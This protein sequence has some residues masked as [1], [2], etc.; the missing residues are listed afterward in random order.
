MT[1]TAPLTLPAE[2]TPAVL[3]DLN[4]QI[5]AALRLNKYMGGQVPTVPQMAFMVAQNKEV[6]YGGA[7]K[8]GKTSGQLMAAMQFVDFPYYNAL[9]LHRTF[10]DLNRGDGIIP[11]FRDWTDSLGVK[12]DDENHAG[13]FP[14]GAK[15]TF[16][17]IEHPGD[18][19]R[20]KMANYQYIGWEEL[21]EQPD[22]APY[23]YLF[24]RLSRPAGSPIPLRVRANSN[25]D[26][27]GRVW[28]KARFGIGEDAPPCPPSR[29]FIPAKLDDNPHVDQE[30]IESGLVELD[31]V[32]YAQLRNGNWDV[33]S[34]GDLFQPGKIRRLDALPTAGVV[35]R[36][37][38][39]DKA[40]TGAD[41][42][43]KLGKKR[44]AN[45][46]FTVGVRMSK[47]SKALY[48]VEYVVEDVIRGQWSS[49]PRDRVI[50][51]ATGIYRPDELTPAGVALRIVR[52]P[53]PVPTEIYVEQEPASGGKQSAEITV[54]DL[55]G[56]IVHIVLP[57]GDKITRARPFASMIENGNVGMVHGAWNDAFLDELKAAPNG[58]YWD[59]IDAASMVFNHL[60]LLIAPAA[61]MA[62]AGRVLGQDLRI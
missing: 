34:A 2:M 37:R 8:G 60:R 23:V 44:S 22:P 46:K 42:V 62:S 20:Y 25:P 51:E 24:S 55:A 47:V 56:R 21:T 40:G 61:P 36:Y 38:G 15:I 16:G 53:D 45:A 10:V 1:L 19:R 13:I 30:A 39:W 58:I 12:W 9:I 3:D 59:Q 7:T 28:V 6:L 14:G 54:S 48:G 11:R 26:G 49:G 18:E 27:P 4:A 57:S 35:A 29:L 17:F 33:T 41:E 32:T 31:A 52:T 50:R 43:N 5:N